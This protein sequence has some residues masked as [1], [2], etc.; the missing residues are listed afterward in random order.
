MV[1][2]NRNYTGG[3]RSVGRL[4]VGVVNLLHELRDTVA[5]HPRGAVA[6]KAGY[7]EVTLW[8]WFTGLNRMPLQAFID[9]AQV[10]GYRVELVP[11]DTTPIF[12]PR[13]LRRRN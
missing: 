10:V 8:R 12:I 9:V 1:A 3:V 6:A 4:G 2:D 13:F 11:Q 5:L 7:E